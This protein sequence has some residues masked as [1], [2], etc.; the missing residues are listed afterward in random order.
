[1]FLEKIKKSHDKK[2]FD[3]IVRFCKNFKNKKVLD[4]GSAT[5][6]DF[7]IPVVSQGG[8]Y[9]GADIDPSILKKKNHAN[10]R[11]EIVDANNIPKRYYNEF[12]IVICAFLL[13]HLKNPKKVI[14]DIQ[15]TL[16]SNGLLIVCEENTLSPTWK[17]KQLIRKHLISPDK[18]NTVRAEKH[19]P[20]KT[21]RFYFKGLFQ[22]ENSAYLDEFPLPKHLKRTVIFK[23]RKSKGGIR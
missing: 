13:H 1:M 16:R 6:I 12:D 18:R 3:T 4:M 14:K 23:L 19:I 20:I 2:R 7:S 22:I 17:I 10:C 21:L 8:Y 9:L 11:Y 15:K 5:G